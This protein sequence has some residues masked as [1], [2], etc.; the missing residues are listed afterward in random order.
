MKGIKFMSRFSFFVKGIKFMSRF[1]FLHV[2][3]QLSQYYLLKKLEKTCLC[4]IVLHLLLCQRSVH[5]ICV[6]LFLGPVPLIC[7]FFHQH[8]SKIMPNCGCDW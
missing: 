3:I 1:S 7:L 5:Y 4:S 2:S 8:Q 6:G